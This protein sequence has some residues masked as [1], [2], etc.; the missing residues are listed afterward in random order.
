ML[1]IADAAVERGHQLTIFTTAWGG[2]ASPAH[3]VEVLE[4][5]SS[6]NH[7]RSVAF[8]RALAPM[9]ARQYDAV[10]GFN[11]MPGL[12]FYYAADPC[13]VAR[14][15]YHRNF[16]Y[17]LTPRYRTYCELEE[18]VF[19]PAS[20]TR[21]LVLS[22]HAR[23]EYQEFHATPD[24]RFTL[25][26]PV[27]DKNFR[28][29]PDI[30]DAD[31]EVRHKLGLDANENL[32]LTVGS[33]FKTKGVD[34]AII[35]LANLDPELRSQTHLFVAGEGRPTPYKYLAQKL[36][37]SAQINFL[38]GRSDIRELMKAADLL[39]H[40]ARNENT[41]TVLLEAMAMG[42]PVLA[43]A[44]CGYA[45][46]VA[47][48]DAGMVLPAPF[49]QNHLNHTLQTM[50][51]ADSTK[52]RTN[53]RTYT[54]NDLFYA[55]PDRVLDCVQDSRI[56][57][58]TDS[59]KTKHFL[60]VA[61]SL[62]LTRDN[63]TLERVFAMDGD[64]YRQAPGRRTFRFEFNGKGYFV[65]THS[66]VGWKEILKNLISL[67]LPVLGAADEWHA[68]H[69]LSRSGIK[70][71]DP[72]AY[73]IQG[74][75]PARRRSFIIMSEISNSISLEDLSYKIVHRMDSD[76][77]QLSG[78]QA[79]PDGQGL[80]VY[81]VANPTRL[82]RKLITALADIA[83]SLHLQG[84]NH[85]DFYLCHFL[86]GNDVLKS[87]LSQCSAS[88]ITL[89]DLHRA[90][91]RNAT[92]KRWV[93]KDL[94]GLYYSA[95]HIKLSRNDLFRFIKRYADQPL[96]SA[97]QSSVDWRGVEQ[98]AQKLFAVS[99]PTAKGSEHPAGR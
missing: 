10:V 12:D 28:S 96:R 13:F 8:S 76:M 48:A 52:W 66:G 92:P 79:A 44:V 90:Q 53:G 91:I 47:D 14:A 50:L 54:E 38:G 51:R 88:S 16:W 32:I 75:N 4:V 5:S 62:P 84:V 31:N 36:G 83:R 23:S 1:R 3:A 56:K 37:I 63:N 73:G 15:H 69:V 80:Q 18:S 93:T 95:M 30:H 7:A 60:Y 57:T 65:K 39:L 33:G 49:S 78:E 55:M 19:S 99:P 27:L 43:T 74:R 35:A 71:P 81:S 26:P 82:K 11:K 2:E 45:H 94:A 22:D 97:L 67:K 42:L 17:R 24:D 72:R 85:R 29:R 77:Y 70:A 40:P 58:D 21:I 87:G 59:K 98:R 25:L 61:D 89:I 64:T 68:L 6:T 20:P 9:L 41:G 46:H 34:R 86:I